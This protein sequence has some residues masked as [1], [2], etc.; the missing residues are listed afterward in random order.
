MKYVIVIPDGA[1]DA[2]Q[3]SLGGKT[4]FQAAR[5]PAMDSLA[6]R[7]TVGLTNHVPD[8]LPP[9]SE[10]ACMSLMGYDPLAYFT[11]RAPLEA[12]AQGITLGA[13]DWAVRCNLVTIQ[14]G[15]GEPIMEDFTAGHI[16]TE[17]A[18]ELL[19][20]A[21][22]GLAADFPG[23]AGWEF[24]PGVSYRNLLLHR[25]RPGAAPL[26][27][28]LR[29]TPPHDL[30]DKPVGDSF[31]RGTGSRLLTE[32]MARSAAWLEGHPVNKAR[33]AAGKRPAT[34]V[35]LWG[36]GRAPAMEPFAQKYGMSGTMI[37]AVDLL[38]GLASLA[39]WKRL[40]VPGATGYLD[41]DYAAKGRYAIAE[42]D[43][44]DLVCVHIEAPDEA[45][46]QGDAAEKVKAIEEIDAKIVAPIVKH[47]AGAGDHRILVCPDHPTFI[48]TKT[49][50]RGHVPFVMAGS[51]I[52]PSGQR[53]YD[54]IAAAAST[55]RIEP[56][57][58]LMGE[59][60]SR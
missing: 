50:S 38:R 58:K 46:H 6:A 44:T 57:W 43:R 56:G 20:A 45:S 48:S 40:E 7:G 18:T 2:P 17:E 11:G 34:N 26:G 3:D 41:T 24:K 22:R 52:Q 12:A 14:P 4:P 42:L 36:V 49:H 59:F 55:K 10:V 28:D 29:A 39:G 13:D 32:I 53:S 8:S 37:T 33:I 31:P 19:A 15:D 30:M 54:E 5:T 21:Q 16:T 1:A 60:L 9:G 35:W 25:G 51:G 27:G 47:L 23:L